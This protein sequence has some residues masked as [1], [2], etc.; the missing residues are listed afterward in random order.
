MTEIIKDLLNSGKNVKIKLLGDSIT[1]GSGGTDYKQDGEEFITGFRRNTKGY[2]WAK[3]FREYMEEK[4]NCT[5]I[6]NGCSGTTIE[7]IIENFDILVDKDD[8]VVICTIGTNN[9]HKFFDQVPEKPDRQEMLDTFYSNILILNK[10]F[11]DANIKV[12]FV[13]NIPA[14]KANDYEDGEN[15]WRIL[16][17]CDIDAL[18]KK[19]QAECGY[20]LISLYDLFIEYCEKENIFFE[21]LLKDGLHPNDDGYRIMYELLIK[22][23]DL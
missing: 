18:Y 7:Y 5:V 21:T 12:I 3:L 13:A 17:M 4:Y 1:H 11:T 6:N 16:H 19:A 8:D 15:Y 10:K 2:C 14:S 23:M 9:R 22:E 20:P